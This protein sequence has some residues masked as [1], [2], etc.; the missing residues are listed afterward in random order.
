MK[1]LLERT[2]YDKLRAY[3][4]L[5]PMEI[6]GL[7]KVRVID[8][9]FVVSDV[10]IFDQA[11]SGAHSTIETKAL[12]QFQADRVR[13]GESMKEWTL[14]WHSHADMGV[15]FS[16]TDTDT[17]EGSSEFPWLVSLVVNKKQQ[18]EARIDVFS[19]VHMYMELKVE[20]I[21]VANEEIKKL[22]QKDIDDKVQ[23]P[24]YSMGFQSGSW[25]GWP[26]HGGK[27]KLETEVSS[28]GG[29]GE[30]TSEATWWEQEKEYMDHKVYIAKRIKKARKI[31][32]KRLEED[33]CVQLL[34]H[35]QWG[36]SMGFEI[37]SE[38]KKSSIPLIGKGKDDER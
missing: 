12:A 32:N 17:I 3:T 28:V 16:K 35:M 15:F 5:C 26:K 23:K 36:R 38:G 4:D 33:L 25:K 29:Y 31:R 1:L 13:N 21:E 8:E 19:P 10:A 9:D 7:G 37:T 30:I 24:Q 34:D 18:S 6:S 22:C 2:A 27:R 11:V 20:I 14:W